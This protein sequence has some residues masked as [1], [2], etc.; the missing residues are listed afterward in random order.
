MVLAR[1]QTGLSIGVLLALTKECQLACSQSGQGESMHDP[2]IAPI[3]LGVGANQRR[4]AFQGK[5]DLQQKARIRA[6]TGVVVTN[7]LAEFK[8]FR[9][10]TH[11]SRCMQQRKTRAGWKV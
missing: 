9:E 3:P 2:K 11:A 8:V 1:G 6:G 10:T 7:Q 4:M 5:E